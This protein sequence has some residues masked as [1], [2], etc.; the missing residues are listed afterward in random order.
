MKHKSCRSKKVYI[1]NLG[2]PK[3]LVD[4]EIIA[5]KFAEQKE[6]SWIFCSNPD[7]ADVIIVNTCGFVKDAREEA[8]K[9]IKE[10]PKDK[11]IGVVGCMVEKVGPKITQ[12]IPNADF[13]VGVG[14]YHIIPQLVHKV[15]KQ[16]FIE[17]DKDYNYTAEFR[18]INSLSRYS[19]YVKISEGCSR[20][21]SFCSIPLIKGHMRSRP[22]EDIVKEITHLS[23]NGVREIILISQDT[24][25]WGLDLSPKDNIIH[26][27]KNIVKIKGVEWIRLF[28]IYPS[29]PSSTLE[30]LIALIKNEEKIVKYLEIP[31]Q[32]IDDKILASM[33]RS[34]REKQ[35]YK[36]IEKIRS[37]IVDVT[38]RTEFIV[39][40][41]G[42]TQKQFDKLKK[43]VEEYNFDW[44][45]IF[46]FSPEE[47]TEAFN[48]K[49]RINKDIAN[50]RKTELYNLW[51]KNFLLNQ[52]SRVGKVFKSIF[53]RRENGFSIARAYFQSPEI[54]GNIIIK[55]KMREPFSE[56]KIV[57]YNDIDLIG[58]TL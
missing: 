39:G 1:L 52:R 56:I 53:E 24:I 36:L 51:Y 38:L 27:I 2:C 55:G 46:C 34:L 9:K 21:C 28:Y 42:E 31:F 33:K 14:K 15:D 13:C 43:F 50:S 41:P 47:G 23:E 49:N 58:K 19:A 8:I 57:G 12:L 54:E 25:S 11:I 45:G 35:I 3:N 48:L 7:S 20:G 17:G 26:L 5:Q 16:I 44:I 4:S 32:H 18:R 40:F 37:K 6:I 29:F 10:L 30:E 22:L